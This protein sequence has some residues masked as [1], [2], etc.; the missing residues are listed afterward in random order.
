MRLVARFGCLMALGLFVGCG[1]ST[2]QAVIEEVVPVAGTLRFQGK[3]LEFFQ[4]TLVP[5]DGRRAATGVTD[6]DGNF[7]L[8]TN[9]L[10]DGAPPGTHKVAVVWV[11]PPAADAAG[12]EVVVDDPSKLPKPSVAIPAKYNN[13][14]SSGLTLEVPAAGLPDWKLDLN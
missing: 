2:P 11:G 13:P 9:D 3:P 12:Q 5:S 6:K 4:V 7:K 10:G 14:E 8:G 1:D